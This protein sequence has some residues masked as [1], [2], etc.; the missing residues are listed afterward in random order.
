MCV[1]VLQKINEIAYFVDTAQCHDGQTTATH[2]KTKTKQKKQLENLLNYNR[3]NIVTK[4]RRLKK[5]LLM[6]VL[7]FVCVCMC[8][9]QM[10]AQDPNVCNCPWTMNGKKQQEMI[11]LSLFAV[12]FALLF[13]NG[14]RAA[15]DESRTTPQYIDSA[16]TGV[17]AV[18]GDKIYDN[19]L[20]RFHKRIPLLLSKFY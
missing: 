4:R 8:D 9:A 13:A 6:T 20:V 16:K 3:N 1:Y 10:R 11:S 15:F 2:T 17:A 14:A 12:F 7:I 5:K 18:V 19:C